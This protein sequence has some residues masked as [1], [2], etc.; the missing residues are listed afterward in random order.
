[1]MMRVS[2]RPYEMMIYLD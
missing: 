2:T 1:M